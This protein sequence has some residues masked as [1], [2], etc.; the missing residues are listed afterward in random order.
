[1]RISK[2]QSESNESH[3]QIVMNANLAKEAQS[4]YERELIE[5]AADVSVMKQYKDNVNALENTIQQH[6]MH[7]NTLQTQ[8]N[9]TQQTLRTCEIGICIHSTYTTTTTHRL[10]VTRAV[11]CVLCRLM[12]VYLLLQYIHTIINFVCVFYVC[13]ICFVW[14]RFQE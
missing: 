5:H 8:L 9:N 14:H 1:V 12:F 3:E 10:L 4:K 6:T 7:I 11:L 2:L 13:L